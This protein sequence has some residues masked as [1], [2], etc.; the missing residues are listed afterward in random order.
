MWRMTRQALQGLPR[1]QIMIAK[2]CDSI[3]LKKR[4]SL[5]WRMTGQAL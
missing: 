4:G 2:P 3:S 5:M 1:C